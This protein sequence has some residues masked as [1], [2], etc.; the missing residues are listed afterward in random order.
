MAKAQWPR[1]GGHTGDGTM[2]QLQITIA[3]GK[4]LFGELRPEDERRLA[5]LLGG[6]STNWLARSRDDPGGHAMC[7]VIGVGPEGQPMAL[8][9]PRA[10]DAA[11]L[12]RALAGGPVSAPLV[13]EGAIA[14]L[15]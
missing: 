14:G 9:L 3:N 12:R 1:P 15:R 10:S 6:R 13:G 7:D 11:A 5:E 4:T 8:G 2:E